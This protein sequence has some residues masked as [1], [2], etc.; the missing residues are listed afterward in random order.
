MKSIKSP[1]KEK[2]IYT[3]RGSL[4]N[5][6]YYNKE[7]YKI[8]DKIEYIGNEEKSDIKNLQI[9]NQGGLILLRVVNED[10]GSYVSNEDKEIIHDG[11]L[12]GKV[13][14]TNEELNFT[15]SFDLSIES[16]SEKKFKTRIT[17]EMPKGNLI[18]EG[19]TNYQIFGTDELVFKRY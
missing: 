17:L 10:I 15:I 8:K 16:K 13:G 11:T 14:V 3:I 5:G 19:T 2:L 18:Q 12:I 1:K 9:S 4:E 7:E 6:V